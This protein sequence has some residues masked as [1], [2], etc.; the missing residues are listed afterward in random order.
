MSD[1][2]PTRNDGGVDRAAAPVVQITFH[3]ENYTVDVGANGANPDFYLAML[4][5]A[6]HAIA[7]FALQQQMSKGPEIALTAPGL[8]LSKLRRH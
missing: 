4:E 7:T 8:D 1:A 2:N 3:P 5:M 6:K